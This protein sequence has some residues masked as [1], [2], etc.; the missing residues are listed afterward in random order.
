MTDQTVTFT[1]NIERYQA[2]MDV[3]RSQMT[4]CAF[5]DDIKVSPEHFEMALEAARHSP[6]DANAQPWHYVVVADPGVKKTIANYFVEEARKR[7]KLKMKFPT[8]TYRGLET[9]LGFYSGRCRLPLR[10]RI[11]GAD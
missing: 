5:R 6:S 8:P 2:L 4:S 1:P 7:A 9:A 3:I 11:S 10:A